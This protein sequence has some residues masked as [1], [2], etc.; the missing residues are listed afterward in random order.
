MSAKLT[1]RH[2]VGGETVKSDFIL[3]QGD[4]EIPVRAIIGIIW[5]SASESVAVATGSAHGPT[6]W[7][8]VFQSVPVGTDYSLEVIDAN[9]K[10]RLAISGL[11]DVEDPVPR[12]PDIYYPKDDAVI[13]PNVTCYG[14]FN[15][16]VAG[17]ISRNGVLLQ[18]GTLLN[19][20]P[21]GHWALQFNNLPANNAHDC[22][23]EV[24]DA[25][26]PAVSNSSVRLEVQA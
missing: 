26:N 12:G 2:P 9:S 16:P 6:G 11:F 19:G 23:F 15:N 3:A 17:S 4:V 21:A 24:H 22:T 5:D 20:M 1:I 25:H 7:L 13:S 8:L 14:A 10:E 18:N